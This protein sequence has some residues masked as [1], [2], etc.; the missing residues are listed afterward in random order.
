M[1]G[2]AMSILVILSI[3][4]GIMFIGISFFIKDKKDK[5]MIHNP[6]PM[7][8]ISPPMASMDEA[9][10][11]NEVNQKILELN[12]Y[13]SFIKKEISDQHKELLFLYQLITEKEKNLK[14]ITDKS[15]KAEEKAAVS[16]H[17]SATPDIS[18]P[19][20]TLNHKIVENNKEIFDLYKEGHSVTEI[21]QSLN[22]GKGEV[23]LILDLGIK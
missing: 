13:A 7:V 6:E 1:Q 9:D 11:M 20:H 10:I 5:E 2:T 15:S 22:I 19:A 16:Y 14:H 18:E 3:L 23:K 21:A 8:P 17:K 4:V 12:D